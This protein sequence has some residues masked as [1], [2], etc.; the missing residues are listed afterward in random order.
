MKVAIFGANGKTGREIVKRALDKGHTV[1]VFVRDAA[2][3][4]EKEG[5][6]KVVSGDVHD[7]ASV[8]LCVKGQDAVICALGSKDL[9]RNSKIR[10]NGTINIIKAMK[11]C[12]VQRLVIMSAMGV[13][14]SWRALSLVNKLFFALLM[15]A[16]REDHEA[17]EAAVK[18]SGL[19]WTI[20]RPSGLKNTPHTGVY[21]V[22][23][24]IQ[25]KTSQISRADVADLM[26]LV[27]ENKT[28]THMA[29]T[30]TN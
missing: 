14:E 9:F 23:E 2:Q 12:G 21:L 20:I 19:A 15:P 27:L 3:I 13:G 18:G 24:N 6:L 1:T 30:I 26:L 16:A 7:Y 4:Q 11:T 22:G 17:Q 29:V 25:S 8:E 10:T 5:V 28:H